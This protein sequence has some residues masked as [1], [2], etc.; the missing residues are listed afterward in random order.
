[1]LL[2]TASIVCLS[3]NI[4]FEGRGEDRLGQFAIA[5]VTLNR[6]A[7]PDYPD[8][9]CGVV[10]QAYL[11]ANG[12]PKKHLCQ[13]SWYCDGKSDKPKDNRAWSRSLSVAVE[14]LKDF[15]TEERR[16]V[17]HNVHHY[18]NK[19]VKPRWAKAMRAVAV[20]GNHIFYEDKNG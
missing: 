9:V 7:S 8:D 11:D 2:S 1:V 17:G 18:H 19:K 5:E 10:K 6:V 12:N 20:V 14:A 3:M 16:I 13:F 4:Y 15:D